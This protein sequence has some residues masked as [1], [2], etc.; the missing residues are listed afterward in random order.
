MKKILCVISAVSIFCVP[1]FADGSATQPQSSIV[2]EYYTDDY[3]SDFSADDTLAAATTPGE[4]ELDAKSAI[5]MDQMTGKVLYELNA[6]DRLPPASVTKVMSLLLIAE[7]ID[8]GKIK[9]DDNVTCSEHA[10][11]KGGSQ[12]WLEVGE[13]MTVD[14]LLKATA[15]GSA[16]DATTALAE[17]VAG[18]EEGFVARM[19]ERA[20]ELGMKNTNFVNCTGLDADNHYTS[21]R[22][23]AIMSSELMKHEF[24]QDYTTIWMD[25]LRG[26]QTQLVNTNKLVRFYQGATG[27][28]TGTTDKAGHCLSATATRDGLNL[29]AVVLGSSTG[30]SRFA[31]AKKLLDYGFANFESKIIAV[32]DDLLH[33]VNV[34]GGTV[35]KIGVEPNGTLGVLINKGDAEN[36]E[37]EI[38]LPDSVEAPITAGDTVGHAVISLSGDEIGQIDLIATQTAEKMTY[39]RGVVRLAMALFKA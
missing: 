7:A 16:N 28:K 14:Q 23:I 29:V 39:W 35:K 26:G 36:I 13:T 17:H 32:A 18:S 8:S 20:A 30:K 38:K 37:T 21:A 27:L 25:T 2:T 19:N 11:S 34:T 1:V 6:D 9:L 15:V 4:M 10:M 33:D 24:I 12:I 5:L 3:L 22:D 31:S